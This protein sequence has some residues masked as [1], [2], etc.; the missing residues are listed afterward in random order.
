MHHIDMNMGN[1]DYRAKAGLNT[2]L[3][4][5]HGDSSLSSMKSQVCS[6]SSVPRQQRSHEAEDCVRQRRAESRSSSPSPAARLMHVQHGSFCS[7][8]G[9][10]HDPNCMPVEEGGRFCNHLGICPGFV[11]PMEEL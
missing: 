6:H 7:I 9:R 11:E 1:L 4:V 3:T 10:Y 5:L 8:F 2:G